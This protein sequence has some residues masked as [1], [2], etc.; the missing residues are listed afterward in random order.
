M[1]FEKHEKNEIMYFTSSLFD[2]FD[3]PHFFAA[4]RGGV[5]GGA[6]CSLNVSTSRKDEKGLMHIGLGD[7][8]HP[9]RN[10]G[11]PKAPLEVTDT[12]VS[13]LICQRAAFLFGVIGK[14]A[15][16]EYAQSLANEY[17]KAFRE[18]LINFD[19][20]VV[21]GDCQT[22]QALAIYYDIFTESEKP[23]AFEYLLKLVEDF[24]GHF[25]CGV[26]G[27]RIIFELLTA[28]GY[29]DLAYKMITRKDFPSYG[30][31][32]EQGATTLWEAFYE[33]R[34]KSCN[35]HF[36]GHI[37]GWFFKCLAG[38]NYNPCA[39]DTKYLEIRPNFVKDLQFASAWYN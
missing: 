33:D 35:H 24:D 5:S 26:L 4:K 10:E 34:V 28:Y 2:G 1:S 29:A 11:D 17:K 8:C 27:G 38:L 12:A 13:I 6:F 36:W 18:N 9:A 16:S 22:S 25:D 37:S 30:W 39:D 31:W 7:W 3:I 32:L 21:C 19:N 15:E 23:K 14:T 20:F